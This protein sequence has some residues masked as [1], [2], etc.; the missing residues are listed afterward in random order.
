[1]TRTRQRKRVDVLTVVRACHE[2]LAKTDGVLALGDAIKDLE[3]LLRDALGKSSE[4]SS[5]R[6]RT[7]THAS[8]K[9]HLHAEDADILGA[10]AGGHDD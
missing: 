10:R 5:G 1:M 4:G 2:L 3:V 9:V 8:G 7:N 6:T